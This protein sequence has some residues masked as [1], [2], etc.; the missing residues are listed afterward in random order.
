MRKNQV[1]ANFSEVRE[2]EAKGE[3]DQFCGDG[4]FQF[5]GEKRKESETQRG[6]KF[7]DGFVEI[8]MLETSKE[9]YPKTRKV[10]KRLLEVR[11][12]L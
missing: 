7:G 12:F 8:K 3:R 1:D 2:P 9:K 6:R 4:A 5:I 11:K 10:A